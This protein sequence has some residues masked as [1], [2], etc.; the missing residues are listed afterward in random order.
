MARGGNNRKL[1]DTQRQEIAERYS[2]PLEDGTWCGAKTLAR[3]YGVSPTVIYYHLAQQGVQIR[4]LRT[5]ASNGKRCK[6]I[7]NVPK[8][9][10]PECRCGCGNTT[11]WNQRKNRWNRYVAGHYRR[12]APYKNRDWLI[13]EYVVKRRPISALAA[14]CGVTTSPVRKQMRKLGVPVRSASEAHVGLQVGPL[15]PAWKGGVA[16]W[17]YSSD[18]K[19]LA[20]AVRNRDEWTCQDCGEQRQR[21]GHSLHVHHVDEDKLN[22]APENLVSLCVTCHRRRHREAH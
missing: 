11:D 15:N 20:R 5:A 2:T 16:Q 8:T 14:E 3:E 9:P 13:A 7:T 10:A 1:T 17:E 6:P 21:W 18:W 19:R 12:D 4:D 22:N